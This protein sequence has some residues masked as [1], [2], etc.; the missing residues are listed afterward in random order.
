MPESSY[1]CLWPSTRIFGLAVL[2]I[3]QSTVTQW[4]VRRGDRSTPV[5]EYVHGLHACPSFVTFVD[6]RP[7]WIP[8]DDA[9][10]PQIGTKSLAGAGNKNGC[11]YLLEMGYGE[12]AGCI[13]LGFDQA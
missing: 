12:G 1:R 10:G 3:L 13:L 11:R 4:S 5:A 7:D 2:T 9:L 8:A 6:Q